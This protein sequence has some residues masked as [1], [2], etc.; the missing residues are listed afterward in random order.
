MD[1]SPDQP[2]TKSQLETYCTVNS[3]KP[4][5]Y[6]EEPPNY[7]L[8]WTCFTK[9]RYNIIDKDVYKL[10]WICM[11]PITYDD[12]MVYPFFIRIKVCHQRVQICN[13][14]NGTTLKEKYDEDPKIQIRDLIERMDHNPD[15]PLTKYQLETYCTANSLKPEYC[16]NDEPPKYRQLWD[17]FTKHRYNITEKNVYRLCWIC[18]KPITY[19]DT[20]HWQVSIGVK[21]GESVDIC[22]KC[23]RADITEKYREVPKLV[24]YPMEGNPY[25]L[26]EQEKQEL[27][28]RKEVKREGNPVEYNVVLYARFN[29]A[30]YTLRIPD[31]S[32]NDRA[33]DID[34][35]NDDDEISDAVQTHFNGFKDAKKV[36][37]PPAFTEYVQFE[38][39]YGDCIYKKVV[40]YV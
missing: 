29:G 7:V 3:L 20:I 21:N 11:N 18:L 30:Y 40:V 5:H 26:S 16:Y 10:C 1:H 28:P 24:S 2:L 12:A 34:N 33:D 32:E 25:L 19:E 4:D 17:C 22:N 38:S 27:K 35:P 13:E 6:D 31:L 39:S 9:H 15:Q 37:P 36:I 8:L 23:N 14:C